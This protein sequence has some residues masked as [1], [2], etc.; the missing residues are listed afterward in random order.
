MLEELKGVDQITAYFEE[1]QGKSFGKHNQARIYGMAYQMQN[2]NEEKA[3]IETLVKARTSAY[4][5]DV[6]ILDDSLAIAK[7]R[8]SDESY[9]YYSVIDGAIVHYE[10]TETFDK[11]L[12]LALC[13]KYGYPQM[14]QAIYNLLKMDN[15]Q[16]KRGLNNE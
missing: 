12:A 3:K 16:E 5:E 8:L 2:V 14:S 11:A 13:V 10:I 4:I 7:V 9:I 15:T 6:T 1:L